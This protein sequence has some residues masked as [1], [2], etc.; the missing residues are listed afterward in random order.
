MNRAPG[1]ET[2]RMSATTPPL[3][4]MADETQLTSPSPETV[5]MTSTCAPAAALICSTKGGP[6]FPAAGSVLAVQPSALVPA[7]GSVSTVPRAPPHDESTRHPA[8]AAIVDR[9]ER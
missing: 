9:L 8:S 5:T 6:I 2:C 3:A 1:G 7:I 4:V